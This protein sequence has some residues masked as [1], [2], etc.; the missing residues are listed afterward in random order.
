MY[1]IIAL[2]TFALSYS[3]AHGAA[4]DDA[5]EIA[6]ALVNLAK[7]GSGSE[8][9][10]FANQISEV[11]SAD[12]KDQTNGDATITLKGHNISNDTLC[13]HS[14]LVIERTTVSQFFGP[15]TVYRGKTTQRKI[16]P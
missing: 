16:C 7:T 15:V 3:G 14:E 8:L 13:G 5:T 2:L 10:T 12:I 6:N 11:T 1:R 4:Q 9:V